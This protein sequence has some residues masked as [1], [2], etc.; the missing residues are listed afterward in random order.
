MAEYVERVVLRVNGVDLD[1]VINSV[2]EE[3]TRPTKAVNTMNKARTVRGFKQGNNMYSLELDAER[4]V[5]PRVPDWHALKDAGTRIGIIV[6]PN[7]GD[8]VSYGGGVITKVH[9]ATSDGESS[10]KISCVFKTRK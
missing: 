8:P 4:I 6:Q 1:D 9:D 7:I 10:R 3:S 2:S 5:D